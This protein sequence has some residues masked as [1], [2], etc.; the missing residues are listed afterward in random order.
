MRSFFPDYLEV[1]FEVKDTMLLELYISNE[2]LLVVVDY[3]L[4]L[5]I[6]DSMAASLMSLL[7]T[8]TTAF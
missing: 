7:S 2:F 6:L 8:L 1:Y 5:K 3:L 4:A